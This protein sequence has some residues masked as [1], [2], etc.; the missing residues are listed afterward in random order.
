MTSQERAEFAAELARRRTS[1][2]RSLADVA[3]DA[4]VHRTHLSH[5]EHGRRWPSRSVAVALDRSLGADEALI[6][7]WDD[8]QDVEQTPSILGATGN[9]DLADRI[10]RVIDR[11]ERVDRAVVDHLAALLDQQRR[12]ED[13]VGAARVL[14]TT[15]TQLGMIDDLSRAARAVVRRDLLSVGAQWRQFAAWQ[16]QDLGRPVDALAHHDLALEAAQEIDDPNMTMTVMS[17]KSH[18]AW[19]Q[20]DPARAVGLAAAGQRQPDGASPGVRGLI[21]QQEARGWALDGD[22]DRAYRL[23]DLT[24]ELTAQA[25]EHPEEEPVWVYFHDPGRVLFQRGIVDL[26]LG[27]NT[28]A[29][30][31]FA[32]AC[33]ALP[34]TYRRDRARYGANLALAAARDGDVDRAVDA[35]MDALTLICDTGSSHALADVRAVRI[36]L[37]PHADV[38]AVRE[39]ATAV[40][41]TT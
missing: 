2:G 8:A 33:D 24:E 14:P 40:Q 10:A 16:S 28:R 17:L 9:P 13:L 36:A 5:V 19:S 31:L 25:T 35:G 15:L 7:L 34:A 23:L 30:D 27:R 37:Q 29:A 38:A 12:L 3:D 11:P 20:R 26:E 39:F 1:A 32:A 21:A 22:A 6:A 4:H 41:G 18:L